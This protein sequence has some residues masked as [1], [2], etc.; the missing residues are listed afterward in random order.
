MKLEISGEKI[1]LQMRWVTAAGAP[2]TFLQVKSV[3][4]WETIHTVVASLS[5]Y[6]R[7]EAESVAWIGL[8]SLDDH[9]NWLST[10]SREQEK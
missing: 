2:N 3:E 1:D 7:I 6:A 8:N 5:E 4:G 10:Q 9:E